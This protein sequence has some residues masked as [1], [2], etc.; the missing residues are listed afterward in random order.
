MAAWNY[1]C[2]RAILNCL[3]VYIRLSPIQKGKGILIRFIQKLLEK[4]D[5]IEV[6]SIYGTRFRL[7]FPEDHGWECLYTIGTYESGTSEL[8]KEILKP[9][10]IVF[11]IGANL[12]WYTCLFANLVGP[13]GSVHAFEPVPEIYEKLVL[14]CALNNCT[15][16][17]KLNKLAVSE[18]E[19]F[20]E[21]FT[22]R[23]R[24]HGETSAKTRSGLNVE[25]CIKVKATSLDKYIYM[26]GLG[27]TA[28]TLVKVDVEGAEWQVLK[29]ASTLLST[30]PPMW[31][32][33]LNFDTALSF[34][35]S[36]YDLLNY[37]QHTFKYNFLRIK[38]AWG[39]VVN[40]TKAEECQHGDNV[41]C[42][43]P[44]L[45]EDRVDHIRNR[46]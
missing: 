37:L 30:R 43:I 40:V 31:I 20:I 25:R 16:I 3:R 2:R 39:T 42:F 34:G 32:I 11:D 33:E 35:W 12:G 8:C 19:G 27:N 23:G 38:G 13:G 18:S 9:G 22:F 36:P 29:G 41:L 15:N 46:K 45:H 6:T 26:Q 28:V 5:Y 1:G 10:D 14:N 24:P 17:V 44:E 4:S 7:K 21:L